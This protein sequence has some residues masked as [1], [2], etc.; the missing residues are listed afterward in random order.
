MY[1]EAPLRW[2][3]THEAPLRWFFT[4]EAELRGTKTLP[5]RPN[6]K[7]TITTFFL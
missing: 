2:F 7:F 6:Q 5:L 1:H 3:F 4:H